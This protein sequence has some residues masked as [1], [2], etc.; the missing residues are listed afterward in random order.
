MDCLAKFWH[1][2]CKSARYKKKGMTCRFMPVEHTAPQS[3]GGAGF[4][5]I[6]VRHAAPEL[7]RTILKLFLLF[8]HRL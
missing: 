8:H 1:G 2:R 3:R 5:Q 6:A 4:G 7:K